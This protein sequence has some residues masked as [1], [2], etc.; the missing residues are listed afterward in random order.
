M[1]LLNLVTV[2]MKSTGHMELLSQLKGVEA[3]DKRVSCWL[4][5]CLGWLHEFS[6]LRTSQMF[7]LRGRHNGGVLLWTSEASIRAC[8]RV[9]LAL[10]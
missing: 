8:F 9:P 1:Q 4:L 6:Y 10:L 3:D 5:P 7:L 2:L